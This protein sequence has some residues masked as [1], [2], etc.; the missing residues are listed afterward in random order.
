MSNQI[1]AAKQ[2]HRQEKSYTTRRYDAL[3]DAWSARGAAARCSRPRTRH[4]PACARAQRISP[5]ATRIVK[6]SPTHRMHGTTLPTTPLMRKRRGRGTCRGLE[7]VLAA[8]SAPGPA[9]GSVAGVMAAL[10]RRRTSASAAGATLELE[11]G[12]PMRESAGAGAWTRACIR[13]RGCGGKPR[14]A[15][16]ASRVSCGLL[17]EVAA[18]SSRARPWHG[19]ASSV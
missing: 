13:W 10:L 14:C 19:P 3:N 9:P 1:C 5:L 8:A 7:D 4:R 6:R 15:A 12:A 18:P 17:L 16:R 2:R 11:L